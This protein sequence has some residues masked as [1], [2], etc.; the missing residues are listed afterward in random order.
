MTNAEILFYDFKIWEENREKKNNGYE[1]LFDMQKDNKMKQ[2]LAF[3]EEKEFF[4]GREIS[5]LQSYINNRKTQEQ[6]QKEKE[7]KKNQSQFQKE[8]REFKQQIN[9]MSD[10]ELETFLLNKNCIPNYPITHKQK[11]R[12]YSILSIIAFNDS[13]EFTNEKERT[14]ARLWIYRT[15]VDKSET[16]TMRKD[17]VERFIDDKGVTSTNIKLYQELLTSNI[18]NEYFKR[19]Y[20]DKDIEHKWKRLITRNNFNTTIERLEYAKKITIASL[21]TTKGVPY[22][23]FNTLVSLIQSGNLSIK[24]CKRIIDAF[25]EN[26]NSFKERMVKEMLYSE[27]TPMEVLHY[28]QNIGRPTEAFLGYIIEE[29]RK[30]K[31]SNLEHIILNGYKI[32]FKEIEKKEKTGFFTNETETKQ[33]INALKNNK[34][35]K[36]NTILYKKLLKCEKELKKQET[37]FLAQKDE[38]V[39]HEFMM[40]KN[41]IIANRFA[42]EN[43]SD[44]ILQ[45]AD[46]YC[47]LKSL[48]PEKFLNEQLCMNVKTIN[49]E[50]ETR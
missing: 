6:N 27:K 25:D 7:L 2:T 49:A 39:K 36:Q 42:P 24:E 33:V 40:I 38:T 29:M 22:A 28:I 30:Q 18:E 21:K 14:K 35:L 47:Y 19:I 16:T 31:V 20:N 41:T 12:I 43:L 32:N 13:G 34:K 17:L 26:K 45:H 50:F 46:R 4:K 23:D 44:A 10:K 37:T 1:N 11:N 48:L 15:L 9:N 8:T 5:P 3:I